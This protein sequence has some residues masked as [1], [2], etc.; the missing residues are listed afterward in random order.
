MDLWRHSRYTIQ[1]KCRLRV[2][3][4]TSAEQMMTP[5]KKR[6]VT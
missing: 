6:G 5:A 2:P 3:P 4:A 1:P